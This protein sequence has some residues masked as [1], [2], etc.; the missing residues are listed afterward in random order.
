MRELRGNQRSR[1]RCRWLCLGT[2]RKNPAELVCRIL[3]LTRI[4]AANHLPQLPSTSCRTLRAPRLARPRY[5]SIQVEVPNT[6]LV[7]ASLTFR[8]VEA[9]GSGLFDV[10]WGQFLT[11]LRLNPHIAVVPQELPILQISIAADATQDNHRSCFERDC[12]VRR[13]SIAP[14]DLLT[15]NATL[16]TRLQLPFAVHCN[17]LLRAQLLLRLQILVGCPTMR[18][19][20]QMHIFRSRGCVWHH[21]NTPLNI[22]LLLWCTL[23]RTVARQK[24]RARKCQSV[25][26][27]I[28]ARI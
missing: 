18:I 17:Y 10:C 16:L 20:M 3:P 5:Y 27:K 2:L 14:R 4:R 26:T 6:C 19:P 24:I 1:R 12:D 7:N 28:E 13:P 21:L 11:L 8:A 22:S 25:R 9:W 23:Y 15:L